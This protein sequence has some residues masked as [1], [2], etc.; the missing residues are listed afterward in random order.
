MFW[1][2]RGCSQM[3]RPWLNISASGVRENSRTSV[4]QDDT[5]VHLSTPHRQRQVRMCS[6]DCQSR[7]WPPRQDG[8]CHR[9]GMGDDFQWPPMACQ[10]QVQGS[11]EEILGFQQRQRHATF[12]LQAGPN[13]WIRGE[14]CGERRCKA[15]HLKPQRHLECLAQRQSRLRTWIGICLWSVRND[16]VKEMKWY[17]SAKRI[18]L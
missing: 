2:Q 10:I 4:N 17:M 11:G 15:H 6:G 13:W 12:C 3:N 18:G 7:R 8:G 1:M 9:R 14:G 5:W 16:I